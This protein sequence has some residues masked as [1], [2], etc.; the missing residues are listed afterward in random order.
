VSICSPAQES[1]YYVEIIPEVLDESCSGPEWIKHSATWNKYEVNEISLTYSPSP[2]NRHF[3]PIQIHTTS[4]RF[5][6]LPGHHFF[7]KFNRTWNI[8]ICLLISIQPVCTQLSLNTEFTFLFYQEGHRHNTVIS[9]YPKGYSF[10]LE[11]PCWV[12][13]QISRSTCICLELLFTFSKHLLGSKHRQHL[14]SEQPFVHTNCLQ[15]RILTSWSRSTISTSNESFHNFTTSL[16]I[17]S[18]T[19]LF[20]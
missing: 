6:G 13:H 8:S 20:F 1:I 2:P 16:C 14:F 4:R 15:L 18:R 19:V 7:S 5:K 17:F 10:R 9:F 12:H 11:A 3:I